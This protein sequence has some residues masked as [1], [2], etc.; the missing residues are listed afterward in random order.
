[1][2]TFNIFGEKPEGRLDVGRA[3]GSPA[4]ASFIYRRDTAVPW[5]DGEEGW[6][7]AD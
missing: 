5:A 7:K 2:E 3:V 1:L 4:V 6:E